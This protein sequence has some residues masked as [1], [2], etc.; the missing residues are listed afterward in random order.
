MKLQDIK[1]E[2]KTLNC[3]KIYVASHGSV[4]TV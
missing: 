4:K 1:R 2:E 3:E